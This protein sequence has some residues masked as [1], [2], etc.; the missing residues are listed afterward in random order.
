[1]KFIL[2]RASGDRIEHPLA[3]EETIVYGDHYYSCECNSVEDVLSFIEPESK[4]GHSGVIIKP[5][6]WNKSK[7][8]LIIYDTYCE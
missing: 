7:L 6:F 5:Y 8:E 1:M 3:K 2:R 4:T